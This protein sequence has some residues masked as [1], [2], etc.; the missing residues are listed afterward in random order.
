MNLEPLL[1]FWWR[2]SSQLREM[3]GQGPDNSALILDAIAAALPFI[4]KHW[5]QYDK[6]GLLDDILATLKEVLAPPVAVDN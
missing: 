1:G 3:F 5:P 2:R 4:K 6:D